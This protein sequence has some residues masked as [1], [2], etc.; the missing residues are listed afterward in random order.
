MFD[1]AP[2]RRNAE[3]ARK[4]GQKITILATKLAAWRDRARGRRY[5]MQLSDHHLKDIG[6]SRADAVGEWTKPFWRP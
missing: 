1:L 6:L 4:V 2:A 3:R 5:L